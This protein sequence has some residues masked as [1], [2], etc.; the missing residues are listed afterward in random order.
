LKDTLS[1]ERY[2]CQNY[3]C[4]GNRMKIAIQEKL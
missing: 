2:I 3:V 4:K 1:I